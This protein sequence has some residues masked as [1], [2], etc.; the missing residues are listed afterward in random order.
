MWQLQKVK[1]RCWAI[2]AL[3][4]STLKPQ[5]SANYPSAPSLRVSDVSAAS[6]ARGGRAL[7]PGGLQGGPRTQR[8]VSPPLLGRM[9]HLWVTPAPFPSWQVGQHAAGRS[10]ALLPS[11]RGGHPAAVSGDG[12]PACCWGL[13]AWGEEPG[14][15]LLT[16]PPAAFA[17][18][19][20][21]TLS[22]PF[23]SQRSK[24]V[25]FIPTETP[26][27]IMTQHFIFVLL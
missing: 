4:A 9:S 24:K 22:P 3:V 16:A 21:E 20:W 27:S 17:Q 6:R 2:S 7:P 25:Q 10:H 11:R 18:R 26:P 23:R 14:H 13:P 5:T 12:H 19:R 8:Q 1:H 15:V